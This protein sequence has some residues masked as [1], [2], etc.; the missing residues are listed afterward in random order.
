MNLEALAHEL[1]GAKKTA[2]GWVAFCPIHE[3]DGE[4]H[5]P[6]LA[7][8]EENGKLLV[9]CRAGCDR[10]GVI[11]ALKERRLW[12]SS[13]GAN[14]YG[15]GQATDTFRSSLSDPGKLRFFQ[16]KIGRLVDPEDL[17]RLA[18]ERATSSRDETVK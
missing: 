18:R 5:T 14:G 8:K 16:T 4:E 13:N 11:A 2:T 9:H 7:I 3:A 1:G 12:P 15:N 10:R 6:S 17:Q